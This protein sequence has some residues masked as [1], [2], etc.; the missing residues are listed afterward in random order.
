[1]PRDSVATPAEGKEQNERKEE[2][3]GL[4]LFALVVQKK[5]TGEKM[6]RGEAKVETKTEP[7]QALGHGSFAMVVCRCTWLCP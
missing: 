7:K 3:H 5:R 2:R 6:A 4:I 1:V